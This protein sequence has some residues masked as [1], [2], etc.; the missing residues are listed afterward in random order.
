MYK[1]IEIVIK[2]ET[3]FASP[4]KGDT[5]FGHFFWQIVYDK[6]L[7]Q[8]DINFLINSYTEEPFVIFS[9]AILK[10]ENCWLF[11]RPAL[12]LHF[13]AEDEE[14]DCFINLSTRKERK[15]KKFILVGEDLIVNAEEKNLQSEEVVK[16]VSRVRNSISRKFFTT[17]EHFAPYEVEEFWFVSS[18]VLS[19]FCLYLEDVISKESIKT[20]FERIG[21]IG[22]GRDASLGLGKF[23]VVRIKELRM[24]ELLEYGYTL[25]PSVPGEK[26]VDLEKSWFLPFIRFGK[27]GN[28]FA[29]SRNPFKEPVIMADEGAIFCL[30]SKKEVP[31][32]GRGIVGGSKV[33]ENC[34][35]QGYSIILPVRF[36]R[37]GG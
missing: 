5:I 12:P 1:L 34:L 10:K 37:N 24:P 25:S 17:G 18:V 14:E 4:L 3:A 15:R 11:P 21:K 8:K 30:K 23:E 36:E 7:V 33:C 32:I 2:P 13:F 6:S 22:F 31:F 19:I 16:R 35:T 27:H 29:I 28:E 9:S 26:E 20:A